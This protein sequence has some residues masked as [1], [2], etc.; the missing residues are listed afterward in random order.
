MKRVIPLLCVVILG[1]CSDQGAGPQNPVMASLE[2][3]SGDHQAD[4]VGLELPDPLVVVV[5]DAAGQPLQGQVVNFVVTSGGGTVFAGANS[6]NADGIAKERWTLGTNASDSQVVEVR[7]VDNTTGQAKVFARFEAT[8][9]PGAPAGVGV[10]PYSV[11]MGALGDTLRLSDT[12]YDRY[13]NL[14]P[15]PQAHWE[16]EDSSIVAI[17]STGLLFALAN[18]QTHAFVTSGVASDSALV[19]VQQ[20]AT[21]ID[22]TPDAYDSATAISFGA[23]GDTLAASVT[24]TDALGNAIAH[25]AVTWM[26]T[27][28]LV[29]SVTDSGMITARGPGM[30]W[31]AAT[32]AGLRDSAF[33]RVQQVVD[34]VYVAPERDTLFALTDTTRFTAVALDSNDFPIAGRQAMW[35]SSDGSIASV[36]TDGVVT[37]VANGSAT[38]MGSVD[39][40]GGSA[41]ILVSQAIASLAVSPSGA[42][43]SA[44]GQSQA[45]TVQELDAKGVA[46]VAPEPVVWSSLNADVATIDAQTGVATGLRDGQA[47]IAAAAG[48]AAGYALTTIEDAATSPV[49]QFDTVP[50]PSGVGALHDVWGARDDAVWAVGDSLTVLFYDGSTWS[51]VLGA[52]TGNFTAVWGSSDSDVWAFGTQLY[53]FDGS[54]WQPYPGTQPRASGGIASMWGSAPD[55]V[56]IAEQY[57]LWHFDGS[58]WAQVPTSEQYMTGVWGRA[59]DD[60]WFTGYT[61]SLGH[62]DGQT[63]QLVAA[64]PTGYLSFMKSGLG[65]I[66][67]TGLIAT[68]EYQTFGQIAEYDGAAWSLVAPSPTNEAVEK[69]WTIN[70]SEVW[71]ASAGPLRFDGGTSWTSFTDPYRIQ[72]STTSRSGFLDSMWGTGQGIVWGVGS[73]YEYDSVHYATLPTRAAIVRGT[74]N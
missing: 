17:D 69:L 5:K 9:I 51:R 43:M 23:L 4:T 45:F 64:S 72:S 40:A 32:L 18:G 56:W 22:V 6:T 1:A 29:V 55:D 47:T 35:R 60:V 50:T 34:S 19:T 13:G 46:M 54:S 70:P 27:D 31:V 12:A 37:A 25:P 20:H 24:A 65:G 68:G 30:T 21:T 39:G 59:R 33:I 16:V 74:R 36:D 10:Q 67:A 53:H 73:V 49:T 66:G 58:A 3:V 14:I 52:G 26:S 15:H 2:I 8:A 42:Y 28:S 62:Y 61:G 48:G 11:V 57:G 44:V 41:T 71:V 38:I 63:V 7:A